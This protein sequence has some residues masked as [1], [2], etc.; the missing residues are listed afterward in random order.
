MSRRAATLTTLVVSLAVLAG[1]PAAWA[2]SREPARVGSWQEPAPAASP[3][4]G[5]APPTPTQTAAPPAST[6]ARPPEPVRLTVASVG[7]SVSVRP[8]GV[9]RDGQV[10]IPAD[11]RLA[12][13]YR[14]GPAPG[15]SAGSAV[16]VGHRDSRTQGRGGFYPLGQVRPGAEVLVTRADGSVVTYR[17]VERQRLA[18]AVLP[19]ES[20]FARD[21]APRLT[22]ITCGGAYLP[23]RGGYQDNVVVTAVPVAGGESGG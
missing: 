17:V 9:A 5:V 12:G 23:D 19:T 11:A 1:I 22:L 21:G 4:S 2:W 13:W 10:E 14:F 16:L 3:T 18:K 20:L 15:A 8:V 6:P 7:V